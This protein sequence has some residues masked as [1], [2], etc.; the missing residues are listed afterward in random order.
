[1]GRLTLILWWMVCTTAAAAAQLKLP[2]SDGRGEPLA[3][4]PSLEATLHQ[5][6]LVIYLLLG[7]VLVALA[8]NVWISIVFLR[9]Q[10]TLERISEAIRRVDLLSESFRSVSAQWD[11]EM[12]RAMPDAGDLDDQEES[13]PY[14]RIRRDPGQP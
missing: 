8:I 2:A 14:A 1:M 7:A 3:S 6:Q 13:L 12:Q 10:Y 4:G 5:Q 9:M 11:N